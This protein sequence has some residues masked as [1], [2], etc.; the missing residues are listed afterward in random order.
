MT[1]DI[2]N[3]PDQNDPEIKLILS[4]LD[5]ANL[6]IPEGILITVQN[7]G[8]IKKGLSIENLH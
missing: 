6:D 2:D 8:M 5:C 1:I 4:R 3:I 7:L